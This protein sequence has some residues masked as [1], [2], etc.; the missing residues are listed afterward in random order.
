M[1]W[2]R[3]IVNQIIGYLH[4]NVDENENTLQIKNA[5][6]DNSGLYR[7]KSRDKM[8]FLKLNV[9]GKYE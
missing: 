9:T 6:L 5:I 7:C 3:I 2:E 1:K 8:V 4:E